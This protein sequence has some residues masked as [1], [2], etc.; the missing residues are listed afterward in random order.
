MASAIEPGLPRREAL[1]RAEAAIAA[2]GVDAGPGDAR[3]LLLHSLG[4]ASADLVLAGDRPLSETDASALREAL[5][6]RLAAAFGDDR[7]GGTRFTEVDGART[8]VS[9]DEPQAVVRAITEIAAL[10][11]R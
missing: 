5:G 11:T 10:P 9:L 4:I 7:P 3:F 2:S 1:R 6:R 8:F